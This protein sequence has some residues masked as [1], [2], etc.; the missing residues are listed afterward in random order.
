MGL[1]F[2]IRD[3]VTWQELCAVRLGC[4]V[5]EVCQRSTYPSTYTHQPEIRKVNSE[6]DK[7]RRS[8]R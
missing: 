4:T 8:A 3:I 5:R 1:Q 2:M 6:P 7:E